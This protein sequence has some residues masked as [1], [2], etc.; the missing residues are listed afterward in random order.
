MKELLQ[1]LRIAELR[2]W[3]YG[4]QPREKLYVI[5]GATTFTLMLVYFML[6]LPLASKVARLDKNVNQMQQDL[7]WM[8]T[9]SGSVQQLLQTGQRRSGNRSMLAVVDQAITAANLKAGLQRMEPDGQN[10]VKLWLNKSSFDQVVAMLGQLEQAQ[11]IAV[12]TLA[13]TPADGV[14]LIDARI[15]LMRGGS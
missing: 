3:F 4:L 15:T 13:M 14:G 7:V 2:D 8:Q 11:G 12:Q 9:A 1:N 10:T 5:G 6:W